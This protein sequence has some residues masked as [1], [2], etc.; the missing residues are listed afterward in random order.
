MFGRKGQGKLGMAD[1]IEKVASEV[2]RLVKY[3]RSVP[4]I[5]R[6]L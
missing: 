1:D 5:Q 3:L 6:L 2:A 4:Q